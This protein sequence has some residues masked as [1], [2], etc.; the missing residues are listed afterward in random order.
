MRGYFSPIILLLIAACGGAN[1]D[2]SAGITGTLVL[3]RVA[4]AGRLVNAGVRAAFCARD[5]SLSLVAVDRAWIMAMRLRTGWP[6]TGHFTIDTLAVFTG[7]AR[8]AARPVRDSIGAAIV[9]ARG[10]IDMAAGARLGGQFAAESG[11]DSTLVR[12]S[13]HF[14]DVVADTTACGA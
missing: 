8:L 10:S 14:A 3:D 6:A 13:G 5:S 12:L 1:A 7:T 2:P 4:P 9:A 11:R